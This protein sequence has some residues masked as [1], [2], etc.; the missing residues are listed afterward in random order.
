ME[1]ILTDLDNQGPFQELGE[2]Q[3]T[4][5]GRGCNGVDAGRKPKVSI[6]GGF[7]YIFFNSSNNNLLGTS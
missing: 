3:P 7:N 4:H 6:T 5:D 2:G 1:I